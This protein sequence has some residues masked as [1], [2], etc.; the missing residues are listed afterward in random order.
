M[1]AINLASRD[2]P[3]ALMARADDVIE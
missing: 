3:P 1:T 2:I